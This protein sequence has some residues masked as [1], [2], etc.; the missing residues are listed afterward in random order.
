MGHWFDKATE[1]TPQASASVLVFSRTIAD[2]TTVRSGGM[3]LVV[4]KTGVAS[5]RPAVI[6]TRPSSMR[7]I[8]TV[9]RVTRLAAM[10]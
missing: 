6:S 5:D 3:L 10:A 9:R 1:P 4:A 8:L 2:R 7:P